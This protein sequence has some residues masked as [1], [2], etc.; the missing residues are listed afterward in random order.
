M[1]SF[2]NWLIVNKDWI[3]SGAGCVVIAF[4][5][6]L[7]FIKNKPSVVQKITSGDNSINIQSA[8]KS[9]YKVK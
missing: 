4:V 2:V 3:F 6:K 1:D 9:S 7:I 5:A 8:N